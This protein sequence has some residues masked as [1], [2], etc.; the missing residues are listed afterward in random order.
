MD[1]EDDAT[2]VESMS[3]AN[4]DYGELQVL[5]VT[6][7]DSLQDLIGSSVATG[8]ILHFMLQGTLVI[9]SVHMSNTLDQM[10]RDFSK[11]KNIT[12]RVIFEIA[13]IEFF[14]KYGFILVYS[15]IFIEVMAKVGSINKEGS[16][17]I[18]PQW[19]MKRKQI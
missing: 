1:T 6:N 3:I 15:I 8:Q 7:R 4:S 10:A 16:N 2:F 18:F 12:Q 5:L 17:C 11:E 14:Q 13:L 19:E 9:K